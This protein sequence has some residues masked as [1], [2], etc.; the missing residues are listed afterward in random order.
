MKT[1]MSGEKA[2]SGMSE[3]VDTQLLKDL[4]EETLQHISG[5]EIDMPILVIS[6][7]F[8]ITRREGLG[9]DLI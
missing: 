1:K 9:D 3:P 7:D 4:S 8:S 5:G 6:N 2:G